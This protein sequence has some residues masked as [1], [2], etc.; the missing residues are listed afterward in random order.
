VKKVKEEENVIKIIHCEITGLSPLLMNRPDPSRFSTE[1]SEGK[2]RKGYDV[3][4]EAE[5]GAYRDMKGNL[6]IPAYALHRCMING[7]SGYKTGKHSIVPYIS[8][9]VAI[10]PEMLSLGIKEY[11]IDLRTVVIQK[12]RVLKARPVIKSWSVKLE[13]H[14]DSTDIANPN[15][16]KEILD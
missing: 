8:G 3:E 7:A 6:A 15:V 2:K 14:Y 9:S 1:G 10:I 16:L 12:Q 4:K 5:L 13:I 11:E